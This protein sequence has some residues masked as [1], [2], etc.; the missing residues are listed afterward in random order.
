MC[1]VIGLWAQEQQQSGRFIEGRYC[2]SCLDIYT[3]HS[4]PFLC[5]PLSF[6]RPFFLF[7]TVKLPA[8]EQIRR[9]HVCP[10]KRLM[11]TL[12]RVQQQ[13]KPV[14]LFYQF[15]KRNTR[16]YKFS[17]Y[18]RDFSATSQVSQQRKS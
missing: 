17:L 13:F 3:Q 10:F 8:S 7:H 6:F 2:A 1:T 9:S 14:G 5:I 12:F 4:A 15:S 16:I 11:Y 18:S